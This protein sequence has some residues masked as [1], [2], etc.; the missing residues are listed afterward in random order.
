MSETV[1]RPA[2]APRI[3]LGTEKPDR[4]APRTLNI[5]RHPREEGKR[6]RQ[7]KHVVSLEKSFGK[8][9]AS[10]RAAREKRLANSLSIRN[11][12][13]SDKGRAP[14]ADDINAAPVAA[15]VP[16]PVSAAVEKVAPP[17]KADVKVSDTKTPEAAARESTPSESHDLPEAHVR[18]LKAFGLT[19][20][21]IKE[22]LA[23]NA[24]TFKSMALMMHQAR[25]KEI[26]EFANLGRTKAAAALPTHQSPPA[27]NS[28]ESLL[29]VNVDEF[30]KK[31]NI[32]NPQ[33][34]HDWFG[35]QNAIIA[36]MNA[37][38]SARRQVQME[39]LGGKV[40]RFF[41]G[42]DLAAYKTHYD[43]TDNRNKVIELAAMILNGAAQAQ[44]KLSL[45]DALLMAHDAT[46]GPAQKAAVRKEVLQEVQ[47]RASGTS[48]R[49]SGAPTPGAAPKPKNRMELYKYVGDKL[50]KSR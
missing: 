34:A 28:Q 32:T 20:E 42:T 4:P 37:D 41:A 47:R 9:Q 24:S 8:V 35:P 33:L 48:I 22:G 27:E 29:P 7:V 6:A 45:E 36:R 49:P 17:E 11:S 44:K 13:I 2:D 38:S 5:P 23:S 31:H 19:D 10:G 1:T 39:E 25:K 43:Q 16:A 3:D 18:S 15:S 21:Q 14:E 26:E 30:V 40:G 12:Q 50:R 46:A